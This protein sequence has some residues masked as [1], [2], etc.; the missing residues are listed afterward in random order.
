MKLL[1]AFFNTEQIKIGPHALLLIDGTGVIVGRC[2]HDVYL[3]LATALHYWSD[4]CVKTGVDEQ[5]TWI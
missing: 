2:N 4:L 1:L 5:A 3:D